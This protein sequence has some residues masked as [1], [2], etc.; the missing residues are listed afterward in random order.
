MPGP[1]GKS[2][3]HCELKIGNSL[4]MI[5]DEN[6][7]WGCLS[8]QSLNGTAVKMHLY[9]ENVDAA[10]DRAVKAGATATMPVSDMF[11]GDRFGGVK[12]P[13]GH[14]W[15][16]ATHVEDVPPEECGRRAAEWFSQNKCG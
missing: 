11:W 5:C 8:P 3:M 14:E 2:L 15:S 1:D 7:Q 12:D 16:L 6:P 9:V 10:V 13:F 4:L